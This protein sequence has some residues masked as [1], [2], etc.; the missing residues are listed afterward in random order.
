MSPDR[1]PTTT[2][3][4]LIRHSSLDSIGPVG[5]N[6]R[7]EEGMDRHNSTYPRYSTDP[8]TPRTGSY[9]GYGESD[10]IE[11]YDDYRSTHRGRDRSD[12]HHVEYRYAS[13]TDDYDPEL[14]DDEYDDEI[15]EYVEPI[16]RRWIWVAGAAGAVLLVAV[17]CTAV[18]LGGG[19]SGSVSATIAPPTTQTS[20]PQDAAPT[21]T[22]TPSATAAPPT[23]PLTPETVTTV[24]PSATALPPTPAPEALPAPSPRTVTYQVTGTRQLI[25]L[26]TIIYTD[27]QGALQT[28]VNVA[29]PWTKQVVL[30]PGVQL[31][32]VTATSLTGQLN[33]SITDAAGAVIAAQTNNTIIANCTR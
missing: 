9:R 28:D 5:R 12:D 29:L 4:N 25:D 11:D 13:P 7:L 6:R 20:Q 18:I 22:R 3:V 19:D 27:H 21:A 32:S 1:D 15:Y 31:T 8:R 26:V 24:P 33:C 30:D 17:I 2:R 23:R 16:D 10:V 14:D